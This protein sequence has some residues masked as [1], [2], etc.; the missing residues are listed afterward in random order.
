MVQPVLQELLANGAPPAGLQ[1]RAF[2]DASKGAETARQGAMV[3]AA[4][5]VA[6][7]AREAMGAT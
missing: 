1:F 3:V 4:V 6:M 7:G 2:S 5:G